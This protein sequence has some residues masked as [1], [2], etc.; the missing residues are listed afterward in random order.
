MIPHKVYVFSAARR[1]GNGKPAL[2][3]CKE[4]RFGTSDT[5]EI[6]Q[7]I[8]CLVCCC[9]C[10]CCCCPRSRPPVTKA[11]A[12]KTVYT[13][14]CA[15]T[16]RIPAVRVQKLRLP[17]SGQ[18]L[19]LELHSKRAG[20]Y[21]FQLISGDKLSD[22]PSDEAGQIPSAYRSRT[23]VDDLPCRR[24]L[25]SR[26]KRKWQA[27]TKKRPSGCGK[28]LISTL[29]WKESRQQGKPSIRSTLRLPT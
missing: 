26:G 11:T 16:E 15:A 28:R 19:Q 10:F 24:K 18:S 27:A 13:R 12:S 1:P 29:S 14:C 21:C 25:R 17:S 8:G 20:N 23:P 5:S 7:S 22:M 2:T 3:F 9:Y 4:N 6:I